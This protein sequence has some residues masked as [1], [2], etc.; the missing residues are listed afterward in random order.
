MEM[1]DPLRREEKKAAQ[2]KKA[3]EH[4]LEL[5]ETLSRK[6]AVKKALMKF[7]LL[8]AQRSSLIYEKLVNN[9]NAQEIELINDME[10]FVSESCEKSWDAVKK[11]CPPNQ[12]PYKYA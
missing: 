7:I 11:L 1:N 12:N 8:E 4:G 2:I 10:K 6:Q 9:R 3:K 5:L